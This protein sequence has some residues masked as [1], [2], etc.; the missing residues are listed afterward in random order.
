M[1]HYCFANKFKTGNPGGP[2]GSYDWTWVSMGRGLFGKCAD[3]GQFAWH[4]D[5][6]EKH[7]AAWRMGDR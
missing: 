5:A 3:C 1:E 6:F 2:N 7:P 4:P